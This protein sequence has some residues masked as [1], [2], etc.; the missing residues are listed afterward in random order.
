M[1]LYQAEHQIHQLPLLLS[2]TPGERKKSRAFTAALEHSV[3][4]S[5]VLDM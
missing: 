4:H 2:S 5:A 1:G 3:E